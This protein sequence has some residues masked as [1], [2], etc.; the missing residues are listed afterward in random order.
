MNYLWFILLFMTDAYSEEPQAESPVQ[1]NPSMKKSTLADI[2]DPQPDKELLLFLAEWS[3]TQDGQWV[4]PTV[5][6][7]DSVL[8]QNINQTENKQTGNTHEN[9]PD[10]H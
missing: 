6:A 5:F 8:T 2:N 4:E 1:Q 9:N 10:H 7:E 3:E